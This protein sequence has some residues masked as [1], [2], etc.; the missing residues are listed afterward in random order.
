MILKIIGLKLKRL[1]LIDTILFSFTLLEIVL[2]I[3][4]CYNVFR[5]EGEAC[6]DSYRDNYN[7][8]ETF[9]S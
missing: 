4:E 6:L 9:L 7:I 3:I 1:T 8:L 5:F 2:T